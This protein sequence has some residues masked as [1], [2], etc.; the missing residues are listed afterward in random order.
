M[1]DVCA[2]VCRD[3]DAPLIAGAGSNDTRNSAAALAALTAWPEIRAALTVV[4]YY[5]RPGERGVL[6][7]F[8]VLGQAGPVPLIIY[9][10]P[11]RTGQAVG[12]GT[13]RE[14]ARLPGVAG[15]KHAAGAIDQDTVIMMADRPPGFAVLAGDDIYAS[16]ML[17]LGASGAILASAHV[18]TGEFAG[19]VHAWQA[20]RAGPGRQLGQRLARLSKALF[21]EPSPA[22]IK[23]VLYRLGEI[24][25]DAVRLPL[26]AASAEAA[27]E[28]MA[29]MCDRGE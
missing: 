2:G 24:P 7:H 5:S 4:P 23:V 9:N 11:Y 18:R 13:M 21:A 1:L 12:W 26:L 17:A 15:V 16:A 29:A 6:E 27:A 10:I 19:L 20:D 28:A 22:V 25:T 8:R 3:R 14:L